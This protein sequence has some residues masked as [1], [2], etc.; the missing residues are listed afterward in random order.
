MNSINLISNLSAVLITF[1]ISSIFIIIGLY[2]SKKFSG[3]NNYLVANR[4]I[5]TFSLCITCSSTFSNL[6]GEKV[7]S[8]I[9]RVI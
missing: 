3:L 1:L 7:P 6:I 2:Y 9:S 4:S 8:P 5:E